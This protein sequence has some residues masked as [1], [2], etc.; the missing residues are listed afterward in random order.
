[1]SPAGKDT[2]GLLGLKANIACSG[3]VTSPEFVVLQPGLANILR[4]GGK[5]KA[6]YACVL[7]E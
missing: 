4:V 5:P 2:L 3:A 6:H 1:M 7:Q